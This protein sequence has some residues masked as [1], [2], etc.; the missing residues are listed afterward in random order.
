[1]KINAAEIKAGDRVCEADGFMWNVKS[2]EAGKATVKLSLS[3][4]FGG[5]ISRANDCDK[6]VRKSSKVRVFV[7]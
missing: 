4:T 6:V 7:G 5:G 1:M 3:P 2:V